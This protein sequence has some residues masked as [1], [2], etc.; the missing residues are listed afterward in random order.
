MGV[1]G[2]NYL[3]N[4]FRA[5][6]LGSLRDLLLRL[7]AV[8]LCLTIHE[9][10]HGLAAYALGDPTAKRNHRLSLNPLRHI[11]WFGFAMLAVAGFGWAKPVP[12][13]PNY[14]RRPKLG[15]ALTALAGP[16]SNFL[17]SL[18]LL[19]LVRPL[20][21]V[22]HGGSISGTVLEFLVRAAVLSVGLGLF[23]LIPIPPLDGSKV[24]FS[25]LPD[26]QYNLLLR[27]ERYGMAI[28]WA[29]VAVG[30]G[31]S[32]LSAAIYQVFRFSCRIVGL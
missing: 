30:I 7:L 24:L 11:D 32:Y 1:F 27:Y 10:S 3:Q 9:L 18:I 26:R 20:S 19:A 6:D 17:L 29:L 2:L 28:L 15:M 13:N 31:S 5:L 25:L 4:L 16:V 23:N 8:L 12:V 22:T 21:V 14:F